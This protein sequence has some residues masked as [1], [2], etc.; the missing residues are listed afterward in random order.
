MDS[1]SYFERTHQRNN[2]SDTASSITNYTFGGRPYRK[3]SRSDISDESASK[4]SRNPVI[5]KYPFVKSSKPLDE[6]SA[7]IF[8]SS[9]LLGLKKDTV[10][11]Q[12]NEEGSQQS[13]NQMQQLPETHIQENMCFAQQ[14]LQQQQE[15]QLREQPQRHQ[16]LHQQ[17]RFLQQQ[18]LQQQQQQQQL[19]QPLHQ[20]F[21][22]QQQPLHQQ[23]QSS[24]Q[25]PPSHLQVPSPDQQQQEY[26]CVSSDANYNGCPSAVNESL[27]DCNIQS[28]ATQFDL[29][30]LS[31]E[32]P[33]WEVPSGATWN[34][35]ESFLKSNMDNQN[36][37]TASTN[38]KATPFE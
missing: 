6:C 9:L 32:I 13:S 16:Q 7:D 20:P 5:F 25:H 14:Q 29:A 22:Q 33:L 24:H 1:P 12:Q 37:G 21:H 18:F 19:T 8:R 30:S 27:Y 28:Q 31:S 3:T 11:G 34:E 38:N 35:W 10:D 17:Q 26:N 23:P 4:K 15:Q 2:C 36:N